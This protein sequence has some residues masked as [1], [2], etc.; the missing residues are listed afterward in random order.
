[1]TSRPRAPG[2]VRRRNAYYFAYGS[3][4]D[5]QQM[6][7]RCPSA[8]LRLSAILPHHALVFAG[9]SHRWGGAVATVIPR[10][11]TNVAGVLYAL[12]RQDLRRLDSFEGC[13][14]IYQR[15]RKFVV[16]VC[17]RARTASV[18]VY[19]PKVALGLPATR[20]LDVLM[21]AYETHGFALAGLRDAIRRSRHEPAKD[22]NR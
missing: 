11:G 8:Q 20:Y 13:P 7:E 2:R 10:Q 14:V 16:D 5:V 22:V 21:N 18:Y 12:T 1:M 3:N 15:Y 19:D 6:L 4:L 9:F 17:G